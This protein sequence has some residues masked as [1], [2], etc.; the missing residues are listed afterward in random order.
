MAPRKVRLEFEE[1]TL[2]LSPADL[3]E[4]AIPPGFVADPRAGGRYRGI[5]LSYRRALTHLVRA[6]LEVEDVARAY[7]A[8]PARL[9]APRDPFPHQREALDAWLASGKFGMVVLPTGAGKSYVAELAIQVTQRATLV[10]VPTLD[11]V[12]QWSRNLADS[13][14]LEIGVIGG[15]SFDV[16]PLTVSTYDSAYLHMD[17]LGNRFGLVVFDEAHHLPSEAFAQAAELCIAPYRLGLT[18]TPERADNA[19]TLLDRLTGPIVYRK[20]V[21]ELT[22]RYLADYDVRTVGVQLTAD[23]RERYD[24]ARA[25]YRGFVRAQGIRM[26]SPSGWQQF[27]QRSSMSNEGRRAFA[28]FHEQRGLALTSSGKLAELERILGEHRQDKVLFFAHDNRTVHDISRRFLVPAITHE[29]PTAE[30]RVILDGLAAGRWRVVGTSRVLNEGVDMPDVSVGVVISGTG[31]VRE[32][33]QR[34]GRILRR[35]EGK[36]AVLYE[37]VTEGTGETFTSERRRDHE[38]YR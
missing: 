31:S 23:E 7:D 20:Q 38:A 26:G 10:I 16:R 32:H 33:V 14:G 22:G 24:A 28:A 1:G 30:R 37:L 8:L 5:A 34:L 17:R 3:P 25:E 29:T 9:L 36:R 11:L 21:T 6:G 18:A 15:G 35:G 19:H 2:L 13:F 12:D 27:I 4:E